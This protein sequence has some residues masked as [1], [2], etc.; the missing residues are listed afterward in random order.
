MS[1]CIV[2]VDV[3]HVSM[4]YSKATEVARKCSELSKSEEQLVYMHVSLLGG[5]S[6]NHIL[7]HIIILLHSFLAISQ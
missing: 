3:L 1:T 4:D 2:T 6:S 5:H 7:E